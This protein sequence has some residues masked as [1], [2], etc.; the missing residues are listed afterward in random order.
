MMIQTVDVSGP[1]PRI[2][3]QERYDNEKQRIRIIERARE[4]ARHSPDSVIWVSDITRDGIESFMLG[5]L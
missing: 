5:T 1:E 3:N 4:D 2:F